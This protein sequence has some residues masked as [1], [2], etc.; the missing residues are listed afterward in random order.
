MRGGVVS[1]HRLYVTSFTYLYIHI[2]TFYYIAPSGLQMRRSFGDYI[3]YPEVATDTWLHT[4]VPY[5]PFLIPQSY[6]LLD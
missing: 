3:L 6:C 2:P 5:A 1:L 4:Y